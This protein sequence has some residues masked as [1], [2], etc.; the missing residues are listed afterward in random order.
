[1]ARDAAGFSRGIGLLLRYGVIISF[2]MVAAGSLL[3]FVQGGTGYSPLQDAKGMAGSG[4]AFPIAFGDV[5]AGALQAKPF[6]LI[7]LGLLALFATP[8][9][10]VA[11]SILLFLK[12]ERYAFV[13][14]TVGVLSVL[15]LS[16]TVVAPS[17]AG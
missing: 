6:A 12:E 5:V 9:I 16:I 10:R 3:L 2:A 15:L 13:A 14:I 8:V 4:V 1:M 17:L 7:Q 11:V